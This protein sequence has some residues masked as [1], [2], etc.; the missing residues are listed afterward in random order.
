MYVNAHFHMRLDFNVKE[1]RDFKCFNFQLILPSHI[2]ITDKF[3]S[4]NIEPVIFTVN[5]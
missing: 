4:V 1:R 3:L 2:S 5:L